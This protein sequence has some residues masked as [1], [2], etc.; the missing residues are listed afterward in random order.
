MQRTATCWATVTLRVSGWTWLGNSP[1]MEVDQ[2]YKWKNHLYITGWWLTSP[3]EKYTRQL[4]WWHSQYMET[5]KKCSK[6]PSRRIWMQQQDDQRIS[7]PTLSSFNFAGECG[8]ILLVKQPKGS[9]NRP[10]ENCWYCLFFAGLII[11]GPMINAMYPLMISLL[12]SYVCSLYCCAYSYI[13]NLRYRPTRRPFMDI[14][15]RIRGWPPSKL[16]KSS[17]FTKHSDVHIIF[18]S[19]RPCPGLVDM[20]SQKLGYVKGNLHLCS[21]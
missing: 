14:Y 15:G 4:G 12:D 2:V 20:H 11:R 9:C 19:P 16:P 8:K 1:K 21:G 5:H 3:S 7:R 18:I 13:F 6:P 10:C 17:L